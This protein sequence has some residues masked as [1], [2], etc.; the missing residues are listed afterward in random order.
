MS[1]KYKAVRTGC[2]IFG[3]AAEKIADGV[4]V[5]CEQPYVYRSE[6]RNTINAQ[7]VGTGHEVHVHCMGDPRPE[8]TATGGNIMEDM[9]WHEISARLHVNNWL[10]SQKA[11]QSCAENAGKDN[12]PRTTHIG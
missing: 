3:Q 5:Y 9:Q 2:G 6:F 7:L 12:V 4:E 10:H 1:T 8:V 11:A